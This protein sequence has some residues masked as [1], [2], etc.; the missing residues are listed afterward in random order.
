VPSSIAQ[1]ALFLG[2]VDLGEDGMVEDFVVIGTQPTNL[3]G[4]DTRVVVGPNARIRSHTVIYAGNRIGARFQTGH[5]ALLRE[6]NEIDDDVSVGSHSVV[7]HRVRIGRGARIHSNAFVPEFSVIEAQAWIGPGVVLT[8]ARYPPR[9]SA[10]DHLEGVHVGA[11][12]RVGAG[13][14]VLPGVVIGEGALVGAGA[15]VVDN[16]PPGAVVVGNPARV[17]GAVKDIPAYQEVSAAR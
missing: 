17:V 11:R 12:A 15:V 1:T 3:D 16:V 10:K 9:P 6:A 14:V 13:A 7:E 2:E 4:I 8:N 5:G